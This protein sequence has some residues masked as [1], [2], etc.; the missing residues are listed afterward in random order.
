MKYFL[1]LS[2]FLLLPTNAL[3]STYTS[4][5]LYINSMTCSIEE[6]GE[7]LSLAGFEVDDT[8][9]L[10]GSVEGQDGE[11]VATSITYDDIED[12]SYIVVEPCPT[13]TEYPANDYQLTLTSDEV[14]TT[15]EAVLN[16]NEQLFI[17]GTIVFALMF[18][19]WEVCFRP[20]RR[21]YDKGQGV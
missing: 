16:K 12:M 14:A 13:M 11:Y 17:Y 4:G 21:L 2:V 6:V 18:P 7:V 8:I 3:A 19:V 1:L 10:S 9:T 20:V 5:F 15:S